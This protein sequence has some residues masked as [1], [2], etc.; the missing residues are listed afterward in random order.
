MFRIWGG[1]SMYALAALI[2][3]MSAFSV[4]SFAEAAAG[5]NRQ[6][7]FQGKVVNTDGTNVANGSY[8]FLFCL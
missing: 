7:N 4:V 2:L 5:I 6:V 3:F 8:T 1:K